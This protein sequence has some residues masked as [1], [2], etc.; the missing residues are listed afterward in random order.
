MTTSFFLLSERNA[1]RLTVGKERLAGIRKKRDKVQARLRSA[2]V[3]SDISLV[4]FKVNKEA[5]IRA[6]EEKLLG[7]EPLKKRTKKMKRK[8]LFKR[9]NLQR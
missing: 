1:E 4:F 5:K 6:K 3:R 7:C 9:K 8:W 2:Q